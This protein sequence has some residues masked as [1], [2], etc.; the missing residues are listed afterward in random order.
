MPDEGADAEHHPEEPFSGC[1][2][3]RRMAGATLTTRT[4]VDGRNL[5][6]MS[7]RRELDR[8]SAPRPVVVKCSFCGLD[9]TGLDVVHGPSPKLCICRDCVDLCV[10]IFKSH[11]NP[12]EV[13]QDVE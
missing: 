3:A 13:S 5:G 11:E 6:S 7:K 2:L 10:E 9:R 4:R 1:S 8:A 12:P